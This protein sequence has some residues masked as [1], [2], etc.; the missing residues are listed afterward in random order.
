MKV[1]VE[2]Q[3]QPLYDNTFEKAAALKTRKPAAPHAF[4]VVKPITPVLLR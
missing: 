2:V 1:D 3:N 4:V